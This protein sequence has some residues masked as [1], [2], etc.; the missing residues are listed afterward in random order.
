M[1]GGG[2]L[3]CI[4]FL[5]TTLFSS[6]D[7]FLKAQDIGEQIKKKIE[8]NNT[9]PYAIYVDAQKDTGIITKP[10]GGEADVRPTDSFNLSFTVE[11]DYQFIKWEVYD[12]ATGEAIDDD[13]YLKIEEPQQIDTT[14]TF[15]KVPEN[16]N[17]ELAIYA[18]VAKRPQI[19]LS[20]PT[21]QE[22]GSPASTDIQVFFDQFNMDP[23][24]IYYTEEEMQELKET[25]KLQDEDF[26]QGDETLCGGRYYG[27][28]RKGNK[29]FKNIQ[30]INYD[31]PSENMNS[32]F[33]NPYWE[34]EPNT[35]GGSTLVIQTANPLPPNGVTLYVSLGEN[36]SYYID[37]IQVK[38]LETKAWPYK[39]WE[40]SNDQTPPKI[41]PPKDEQNN[42]FYSVVRVKIDDD[43]ITIPYS[44]D[45][46][47]IP[48][49]RPEV[50]VN[51]NTTITMSF[52]FE[53]MD[54]GGS[55]IANRFELYCENVSTSDLHGQTSA[56]PIEL[57]YYYKTGNHAYTKWADEYLVLKTRYFSFGTCIF[58][59][60][61]IDN[62]GNIT[63]LK[64]SNGKEL[65]FHIYLKSN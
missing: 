13:T 21:Y 58:S 49:N 46:E 6:C 62:D 60:I 35:V 59:I 65:Y 29:Y 11:S 51:A 10:A 39:I 25:L 18:V 48:A 31:D 19:F 63:K 34:K 38:L 16:P 45:K 40:S 8:Y 9:E 24:S 5:T 20:K 44:T 4:V 47:I 12:A 64:D 26:L 22:T 2:V 23:N 42:T 1:Y 43:Y 52:C 56:P 28:Q 27:Y 55:G 33:C 14:C 57:P 50:T 61:V 30:I 36:F 17:I 3:T 15:Q 7:S 37:G 32:C 41:I 53:A 54:E